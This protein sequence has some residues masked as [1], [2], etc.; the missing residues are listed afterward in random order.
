[1]SR[2]PNGT[3]GATRRKLSF[4]GEIVASHYISRSYDLADDYLSE[5]D[6]DFGDWLENFINMV[7]A[8]LTPFL[9][10]AA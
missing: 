6:D 2:T 1:M 9:G 4:L 7:L 3:I 10:E 8:N 5:N